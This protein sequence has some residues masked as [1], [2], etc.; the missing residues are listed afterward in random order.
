M[1]A[2]LVVEVGRWFWWLVFVVVVVHVVE[3]WFGVE[4]SVSLA[5]GYAENE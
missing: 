1:H 4:K 3:G 5:C 2:S